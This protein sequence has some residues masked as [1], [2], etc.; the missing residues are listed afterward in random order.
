MDWIAWLLLCVALV[1]VAAL[2]LS[3]W[4][5]R[6]WARSARPRY[7][8]LEAA[9]AVAQLQAAAAGVAR[10]DSAELGGLPDAVQRYFR[11][12][13]KQ[14]QP[15]IST[16]EIDLTGTFNM[17]AT[18]EQWRP[19]SSRQRAT[20]QRPG[21]LWDARVALLPGVPVRVIDSYV[22]GEGELRAAVLGLYT[23]A[24]LRGTG[25]IARGE[26]MRYF[27]E[28]PWYPTALLPSQGVHWQA[29]AA[30]AADATLVDGPITLT[31][32]V[33]FNAL[34]L[35]ESMRA[36]ARGTQVGNQTIMVP[37]ECRYANYQQREG[38]L[39]PFAG[40]AAWLR[41]ERRRAYFKGNVTALRYEYAS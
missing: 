22:A 25:E 2:G 6:H 26:L 19:F 15:I 13:L 28:M 30:Q 21:F 1:V 36:D 40:E 17:S 7:A 37:W 3:A 31:L 35:I 12:V 32:H 16:A 8:A 9:R 24:V 4:G 20:T 18:G 41:P 10:Y 34:G 5:A 27:A 39:V 23:V 11:A 33:H 29:V 38:V 14:G